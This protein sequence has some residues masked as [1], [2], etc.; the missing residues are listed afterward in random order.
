MIDPKEFR[1]AWVLLCERFNREA[2]DL[3]MQAYY[4]DLSSQMDTGMFKRAARI[5]FREREFFPRPVD[6][7]EAVEPDSEAAALTQWGL[8]QSVMAGNDDAHRQLD[9]E[10]RRVVQLIGG[11]GTLRNTELNRVHFVRREFFDLYGKAAEIARREGVGR[12]PPSPA[13]KRITAAAMKG[14]EAVLE[15]A[16]SGAV[17]E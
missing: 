10:S 16:R 12:I 1:A 6:F 11:I 8:V 13:A 4:D 17:D 14:S 5:V 3:L 9:P 15:L 7:L 2:S